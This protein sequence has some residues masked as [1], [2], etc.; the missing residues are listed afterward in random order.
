MFFLERE[1][2]SETS[3]AAI[4]SKGVP[5]ESVNEAS[6]VVIDR[7]STSHN[8]FSEDQKIIITK[9]ET[10]AYRKG[11]VS[12]KVK[13]STITTRSTEKRNATIRKR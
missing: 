11:K 6:H 9:P 4:K 13:V 3:S 7:S 10:K 2:L 1:I 12:P 5:Y 8:H